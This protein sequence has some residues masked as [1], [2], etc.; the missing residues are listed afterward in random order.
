MRVGVLAAAGAI[1]VLGAGCG[2]AKSVDISAV[3]DAF[4]HQGVALELTT[5]R[6]QVDEITKSLSPGTGE[7]PRQFL[8]HAQSA[9]IAS[10]PHFRT[11]EVFDDPAWASKF[12]AYCRKEPWR[13]DVAVLV[14]RNFVYV[15]TNDAAARRAMKELVGPS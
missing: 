4:A 6:G 3:K 8:D 9:A 1:A 14:G 11:V 7:K 15:G 13:A 5:D 10:K 2:S 12:A